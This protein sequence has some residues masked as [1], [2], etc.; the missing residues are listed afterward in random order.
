MSSRFDVLDRAPAALELFHLALILMEQ[1]HGANQGQ[2]FL[3]V[4]AMTGLRTDE[5]QLIGVRVD[6][7]QRPQQTLRVLMQRLDAGALGGQPQRL[8]RLVSPLQ[9]LNGLRLLRALVHVDHEATIGQFRVDI[10]RGRGEH[11]RGGA[12]DFVTLRRRAS[13]ARLLAGGD[14]R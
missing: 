5:A 1:R 12:F 11:E 14:E 13:A 9:R 8:E 4:A 3:L 6:D 7:R 10:E 2:V